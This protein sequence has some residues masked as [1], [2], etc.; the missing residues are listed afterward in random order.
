MR[1]K[2]DDAL[3]ILKHTVADNRPVDPATL[4]VIDRQHGLVEC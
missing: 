4:G 1:G 2:L 3:A